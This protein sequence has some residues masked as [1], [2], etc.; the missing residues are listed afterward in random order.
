M[1][2][3]WPLVPGGINPNG[4]SLVALPPIQD[5][6]LSAKHLFIDRHAGGCLLPGDEDEQRDPEF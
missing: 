6:L 3:A 4:Q 2:A 1:R 5:L